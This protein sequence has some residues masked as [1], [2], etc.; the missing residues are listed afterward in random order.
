LQ[1]NTS[2]VGRNA[3]NQFSKW[4]TYFKSF[5]PSNN[6]TTITTVV[7]LTFTLTGGVAGIN[8]STLTSNTGKSGS[9][10]P[11]RYMPPVD[12]DFVMENFEV[13]GTT[14]TVSGV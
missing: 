1:N 14:T 11:D 3:N 2:K 12:K 13:D 5:W 4:R 7:T 9:K 8:N 6:H 10:V